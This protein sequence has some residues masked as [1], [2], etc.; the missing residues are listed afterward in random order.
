LLFFIGVCVLGARVFGIDDESR[1]GYILLCLLIFLPL[2]VA[3]YFWVY[4]FFEE[5]RFSRL[6]P[7]E[8]FAGVRSPEPTALPPGVEWKHP[9]HRPGRCGGPETPLGSHVVD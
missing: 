3:V 9:P 8:I 1:R 6:S 7:S 5:R 4:S 2:T